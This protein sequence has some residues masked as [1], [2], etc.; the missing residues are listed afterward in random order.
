MGLTLAIMT[1]AVVWHFWIA[2]PLA[3][4]AVVAVIATVVGYLN[5]VTSTRYPR[6]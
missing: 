3:V 1:F 6:D 4:G 2:V 5:K